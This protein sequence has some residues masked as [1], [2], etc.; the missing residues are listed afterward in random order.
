MGA[1][2]GDRL[3]ARHP[4]GPG[5]LLLIAGGTGLAPIKAVVEQVA[6]EGRDL[7]GP[8]SSSAPGHPGSCT[9][10]EALAKMAAEHPAG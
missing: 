1:A 5:D 7:Q 10:Y 4:G 2:V 6:Y 3:D 9:T 8:D